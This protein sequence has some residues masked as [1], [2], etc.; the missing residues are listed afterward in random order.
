MVSE[1]KISNME[2]TV[3]TSVILFTSKAFYFFSISFAFYFSFFRRRK[4]FKKHS[5][6][7]YVAIQF[8]FQNF[9]SICGI[10]ANEINELVE[11]ISTLGDEL[12]KYQLEAKMTISDA[13]I[14]KEIEKIRNLPL[15]IE[16]YCIIIAFNCVEKYLFMI[17]GR[18][19][20]YFR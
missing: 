1:G 8:A 17:S 15:I 5:F 6:L 20:L 18:T 19:E 16:V 10:Q 9:N 4:N 11:I 14:S 2:R 13:S 3:S 12:L 7:M